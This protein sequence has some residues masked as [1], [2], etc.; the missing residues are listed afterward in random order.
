MSYQWQYGVTT[1]A[2]RLHSTL[3][4]TLASLQKAGFPTPR[5][6]IDG[7]GPQMAQWY[8]DEFSLPISPRNPKLGLAANWCLSAVELYL[9]NPTADRYAIFQDDLLACANLRD[10]LDACPYPEK[11]YLNLFTFLD[12]EKLIR[13]NRGWIEAVPLRTKNAQDFHGRR[14][15]AGRGALALVFSREA[16]TTLFQQTHIIHRPQSGEAGRTKIDGGIVEAM[17]QAGWREYVHNPSLV[18]HTGTTSTKQGARWSNNAKSFPGE[19]FNALN[20]LDS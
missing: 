14:Q 20:L 11:S 7:A 13:G 9:Y 18:F 16:L 12:N 19:P 3:P 1:V 4:R 17:N 2:G 5:L 6:F 10:Y 8:L 15:Q